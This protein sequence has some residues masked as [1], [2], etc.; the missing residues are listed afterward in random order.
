MRAYRSN[1]V[2]MLS[3]CI[4]FNSIAFCL[5]LFLTFFNLYSI[6]T[7]CLACAHVLPCLWMGFCNYQVDIWEERKVFGSRGQ[8]L[9]DELMGKNPLPPP[10]VSNGKSSNPIK[11]VKRD[12]HS[13]RI[14]SLK[15]CVYYRFP[16]FFFSYSGRFVC[17]E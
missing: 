15:Y 13:L 7:S 2:C 1:L 4:C 14:V 8:N 3:S 6:F 5:P 16:I 12:A 11:I 10:L 9:K 17:Y